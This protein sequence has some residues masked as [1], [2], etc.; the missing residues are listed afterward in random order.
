MAETPQNGELTASTAHGPWNRDQWRRLTSVSLG[1][2]C[3]QLS[4]RCWWLYDS[5]N[6]AGECCLWRRSILAGNA[7]NVLKCNK[8]REKKSAVNCVS[9]EEDELFDST[10]FQRTSSWFQHFFPFYLSFRI[11][12]AQKLNHHHHTFQ[13][14]SWLSSL[15]TKW[16]ACP[17]VSHEGPAHLLT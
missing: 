2:R 3:R 16:L 17:L 8:Q 5:N 7:R 11:S 1:D 12:L 13:C 14:S 9:L 15:S 6:M 10:C 4:S